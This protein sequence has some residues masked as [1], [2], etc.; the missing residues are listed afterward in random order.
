VLLDFGRR[1]EAAEAYRQAV[2]I[3]P[4]LGEGHLNLGTALFYLKRPAEAAPVLRRALELRPD[5]GAALSCLVLVERQNAHWEDLAVL[6]A[7][8]RARVDRDRGGLDPMAFLAMDSSPAEQLAVARAHARRLTARY[9]EPDASPPPRIPMDPHRRLTVGYLSPDFGDHPV[10]RLAAAVFEAHDRSAFCVLAYALTP[11]DGSPLRA[12][13]ER[14]F[15]GFSELFAVPA[16]E[17]ARRIR[18]DGVDVLVDLGGYTA[19]TRAGILALRPA[20]VQVSYLGYPGT[21][22]APFVDYIVADRFVLP[23]EDQ[24]HYTERPAYLPGCFLPMEPAETLP[25]PP[26]R[27]AC[28]LPERGFVFCAFNRVEKIRPGMFECWMGLLRDV[29]DSVLWLSGAAP[30]AE[31]NLR[32]EAERRGVAAERL[33]FAPRVPGIRDHLA[34]LRHAGLF[35]DT[36]PYN[37]H[38][39]AAD[40]LRAGVP[41][42]TC[43]GRSFCGRVAG[44]LLTAL[45]LG[46]LVAPDLDAYARTAVHLATHPDALAALRVRLEPG[47]DGPRL[48]PVALARHLEAA[49]RRMAERQ[50][51]G[52]A[53]APLDVPA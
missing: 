37:A 11:D 23:P 48:D 7:D 4:D 31:A 25:V 45:G 38:A 20:P 32:R 12:R 49:Y 14:P 52:E 18:A 40:A 47:P 53:P 3:R 46:E 42:L 28:G 44:S 13:L 26:D 17:V 29:T 22:G 15:D 41:V 21:M 1:E 34:R 33:R 2:A 8:L 10:G 16:R 43:P 5:D 36:L 9:A 19:G 30:T 24:P 35:L 27:A 39:T 50:A 6:E 51:A